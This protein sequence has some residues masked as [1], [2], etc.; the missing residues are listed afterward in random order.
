M[1]G[2]AGLHGRATIQYLKKT[3]LASRICTSLYFPE[4]AGASYATAAVK[5]EEEEEEK[6]CSG[7]SNNNKKKNGG[8]WLTLPPFTSNANDA[9]S[10]S[11]EFS[12]FNRRRIGEEAS[13]SDPK[14][15]MT[16]LKWVTR[17]CPQIPRTLIQKL[18]RLRQVRRKSV[19]STS[20]DNLGAQDQESRLRR[21]A[22]KDAM[23]WGDTI[24]LP[25]SVHSPA[26]RINSR[27]GHRFTPDKQEC[28]IDD[29]ERSYIRSLELF[30]DPSIIV[31]NK[32][33]GLPVQGGIG[34]K[35]SLDAL[36]ST[37]L[38]YDYSEPPR[39]VHRLDR[40]SSGVLVLGRTQ[41]S[42]TIL[43]SIFREKTF[44]ASADATDNNKRILQR[45]YWALVI[46]TPRRASGLISAPLGKVIM[47]NGK[48]ERIIVDD[49]RN[50]ASQ[51]AIT[52]YRLV[53]SP[54]QGLTW[55]E[56]SPLT[57][58]KHQ[59]R[60]HCAEV[61]G[62]P[63]VGDYKYGWQ[64]H[65]NWK[66]L[67]WTNPTE[68]SSEKLP[69]MPSFVLDSKRGSISE[70][71]P[72]LHLHCRQMIFPDVHMALQH[73]HSDSDLDLSNLESLDFVAPL[74]AHMQRSWD[75]LNS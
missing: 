8:K 31:I 33:P 17:C 67:P 20:A 55:I 53:Q 71:E 35:Q 61:L 65:K 14:S 45:K 52:E 7:R 18:F 59:L 29:K 37:Y 69:K 38:R 70:K 27:D 62:T 56:L 15:T 54:I 47:D 43:H 58:R 5:S 21:V 40:D 24:H 75:I 2:C 30:K 4:Q 16:A 74:P 48:S 12:I 57:G 44:E 64:A 26:E 46:G 25:V 32:P 51:H 50:M 22:A 66:G 72:H 68:R 3:A 60:V 39:L 34:I 36:A 28:R 73:V 1:E 42:A 11:K 6:S 41:T 10:V 23:N 13:V 63:I 9:A 49:N 19:D